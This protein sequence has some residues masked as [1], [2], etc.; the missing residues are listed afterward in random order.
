MEER[1]RL[2][3][4]LQFYDFNSNYMYSDQDCNG[5]TRA[6]ASMGPSMWN[7]FPSKSQ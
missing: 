5:P 6:F 7:D 3:F 1:L 4:I 2:L